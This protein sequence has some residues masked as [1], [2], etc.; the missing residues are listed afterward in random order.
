MLEAYRMTFGI[1]AGLSQ[2]TMQIRLAKYR[3]AALR[4]KIL[5]LCSV[6]RVYGIAYSHSQQGFLSIF[7]F[8]A[9]CGYGAG[10]KAIHILTPN[11]AQ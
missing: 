4:V 11:T 9:V 7:C 8:Q 1:A 6:A 10:A 5:Q 2:G 3:L